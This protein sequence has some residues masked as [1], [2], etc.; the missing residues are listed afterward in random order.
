MPRRKPS[1][2]RREIDKARNAQWRY[3][4]RNPAFRAD[5]LK[6][7]QLYRRP[8]KTPE[9]IKQFQDS[10]SAFLAH[11]R[12]AYVPGEIL[13]VYPNLGS[14]LI[15]YCEAYG[16][17]SAYPTVQHAVEVEETDDDHVLLLKIDLTHPLDLLMGAIEAELREALPDRP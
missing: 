5:L 14:D 17:V 8:S 13:E 6:I 2:A 7:S 12:L 16:H 10:F 3:C 11:W 1:Q 15:G 9:A 4:L